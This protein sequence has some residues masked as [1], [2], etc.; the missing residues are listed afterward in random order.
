MSPGGTPQ[1]M[2]TLTGYAFWWAR[3]GDTDEAIA[4]R[5]RLHPDFGTPTEVEIGTAI[6]RARLD[7][8]ATAAVQGAD[9]TEY[10]RAVA[11]S[12]G[13]FES[14]IGVRVVF[15]VQHPTGQLAEASVVVN[16]TSL[17]TIE[18]VLQAVRDYVASGGLRAYTGQM[19]GAEAT[20]VAVAAVSIG[21]YPNALITL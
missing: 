4:E 20:D 6:T 14:R 13:Q 7:L 18:E 1:Y 19:Y 16:V 10:I 17:Q 9:P 12:V 3:R 15:A 2:D 21:G 11:G 8:Q 5:M